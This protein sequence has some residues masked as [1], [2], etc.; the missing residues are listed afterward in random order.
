MIKIEIYAHESLE[1][2]LL[3]ELV[4][5][6]P[7]AHDP[8]GKSGQPFSIFRKVA[9]RGSS[10]TSMG[11]DIWPETNIILVLFIEENKKNMIKNSIERIRTRYPKLGLAVFTQAEFSEW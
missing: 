6:P 4:P 8:E 7:D 10:G 11:D 1:G 9:G 3:E 5:V 2:P